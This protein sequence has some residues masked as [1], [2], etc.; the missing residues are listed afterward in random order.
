MTVTVD[1]LT[2]VREALDRFP[3]AG[4]GLPRKVT[5]M[6][7]NDCNLHCRHCWP[8]SL[9]AA[10]TTQ[11]PTA[12][13]MEMVQLLARLGVEELIL[14]GGEPLT[15][16]KWLDVLAFACRQPGLKNIYL[17]T[18]ATLLTQAKVKG[19]QALPG[20]K[21]VLQVSLEGAD[22]KTHDYVR[23][24]GSFARAWQGLKLLAESDLGSQ[25]MVTFTEM[26]HNFSE[27]PFLI[28]KV[29]ALGIAGLVSA[30]LVSAGR[31]GTTVQ[32]APP[33]PDQY[34][35]LLSLFYR[36]AEFRTRYRKIGNIA[37]LE[38][39]AGRMNPS[40]PVCL[41]GEALY[42]HA[43]G[44]MF[45]CFMLPLEKY[46]VQG[47]YDRPL[48]DVF[49]EA[50]SRWAELVLWQRRR[51]RELE[52]CKEC[53]GRLHCAGGCMGRAYAASGDFMMV[54]DRCFLRKAVYSWRA[55]A[56]AVLPA[57]KASDEGKE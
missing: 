41:C 55:P 18:N 30:T 20:A 8:E 42:I 15:H 33:T 34:Q 56:A 16:P 13:L 46:G 53:L 47:V 51:T 6:I 11:V 54:E 22:A 37:A 4:L 19:L 40:P 43:N 2:R 57:Q 50:A 32:I 29:A 49:A 14:T 36:D 7:T 17:Q 27:L 39:Y 38:W 9:Q 48:E 21:L 35:E 52:A 31:A 1:R 25:T 10:G 28:E 23:G 24:P 44:R 26:E 45:P 12:S 3:V 5:I